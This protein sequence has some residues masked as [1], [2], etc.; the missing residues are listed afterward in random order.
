[1][2]AFGVDL[3]LAVT[4]SLPA[5]DVTLV[6]RLARAEPSAVGEVYDL[7][8]QTVRAFCRRLLGDEASAEDLV[9][10]VFLALPRAVSRFR[11]DSSLKTFLVSIAA[12]HARHHIRSASRRRAATQRLSSE[13][14]PGG[15]TPEHCAQRSQ[16]ASALCR[17]LDTLSIEHRVTFVLCEVE[18]RSAREAAEITGVPEATVRTRLFH[19]K[20]KLRGA[21]QREGLA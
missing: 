1:M 8:H 17:A 2:T 10:D 9:H 16:L 4:K 19:A 5:D 15:E 18:E 21:L 13:P 6:E 14:L 20:R 3:R 7:Y 12:N 11:Q